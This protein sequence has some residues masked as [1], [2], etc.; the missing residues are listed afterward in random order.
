ME[1]L[2]QISDSLPGRASNRACEP[3]RLLK[4][5]CLPVDTSAPPR[6]GAQ[7]CARCLKSG[8]ECVF[9][10]PKRRRQRKR[11]DTRVAD[12]E[13]EVRTLRSFLKRRDE[14]TPEDDQE[15]VQ[16]EDT[17]QDSKEENRESM[18]P[19]SKDNEINLN[20]KNGV[21]LHAR[22]TESPGSQSTSKASGKSED[23]AWE[24]QGQQPTSLL[25]SDSI[26]WS[27]LYP[28]GADHIGTPAVRR[29][30]LIPDVVESGVVSM[31]IAMKLFQRYNDE[32]VVHYP[33]VPLPR[34]ITADQVRRSRPILFLSIISAAAAST[35][36]QH[37][38]QAL[39]TMNITI[40]TENIFMKGKKSLEL[41]QALL[42]TAVWDYPLDDF[43][44]LKFYQYFHIAATMA[45]DIGIDRKTDVSQN[46]R[47]SMPA[48]STIGFCPMTEKSRADDPL[49]LEY[50][51]IESRRTLLSCYL[52]CARYV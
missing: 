15:D 49:A 28:P 45:L 22:A 13:K 23:V 40:L 50:D 32:L 34:G 17:S 41:I 30:V 2:P 1:T 18:S 48:D 47:A 11:T 10:S 42:I 44:H 12:L 35:S 27:Q 8:K 5:R 43:E 3:C 16:N 38:Y 31:E 29:P 25:P 14:S 4:V 24:G 6:P 37:V 52:C 33:I 26:V 46:F 19:S 7:K 20:L 9:A 21:A 36:E 39:N 51:I